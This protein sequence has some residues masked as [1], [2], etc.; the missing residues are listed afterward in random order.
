MSKKPMC[1]EPGCYREGLF[2]WTP[3]G[4][5]YLC[6]KHA[7]NRGLLYEHMNENDPA[8]YDGELIS[9]EE[10]A[11][12][13]PDHTCEVVGCDIDATG[14]PYPG[15]PRFLCPKHAA[16]AGYC[17]Y[18]GAYVG[19]TEDE[20]DVWTY[21]MCS[22]CLAD[23][24]FDDDEDEFDDDEDEVVSSGWRDYFDDEPDLGGPY[25]EYWYH[26]EEGE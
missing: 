20:L 24:E 26:P 14:F 25:P 22:D 15:G 23:D 9:A 4:H 8:A 19:G 11:F 12:D 3:E 16:E 2:F 5:V 6:G 1:E 7:D 10:V 17:P 21:G 13:D 18:C